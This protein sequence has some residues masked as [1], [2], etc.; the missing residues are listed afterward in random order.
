MVIILHV[1]YIKTFPQITTCIHYRHNLLLLLLV[2]SAFIATAQ[3]ETNYYASESE[4]PI[5][6]SLNIKEPT[7][8]HT[9]PSI[10]Q[11]NDKCRK[12]NT[13]TLNIYR[14]GQDIDVSLTIDDGN[15]EECRDGRDCSLRLE[16]NASSHTITI[17]ENNPNSGAKKQSSNT[18]ELQLW[19]SNNTNL[20]KKTA[21]NSF[22]SNISLEGIPNG[23]YIVRVVYGDNIYSRKIAIR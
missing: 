5:V 23:F 14:F 2:N 8:V 3:V 10:R 16:Y 13:D 21:I 7:R 11:V 22:P 19:R 17:A 4:N 18:C 12:D 6:Q 15:W 9:L 1:L 20:V